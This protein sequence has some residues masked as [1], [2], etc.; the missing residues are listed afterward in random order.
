MAKIS[1]SECFRGHFQVN[2]RILK[3]NL[4]TRPKR[5]VIEREFGAKTNQ[6]FRRNLKKK[7]R[8]KRSQVKSTSRSNF[9]CVGIYHNRPC[10]KEKT[11]PTIIRPAPSKCAAISVQQKWMVCST[12][13]WC[14]AQMDGVLHKW[15][16]C[17]TNGWCAAQMDGVQQI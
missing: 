17:S 13:G 12:N 7:V 16:V 11:V 5:P 6:V 2:N 1:Y 15:M 4:P 9:F 14:A 10:F 8:Y 3:H